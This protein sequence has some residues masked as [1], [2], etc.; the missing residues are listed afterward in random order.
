MEPG[1][2]I[3]FWNKIDLLEERIFDETFKC[4]INKYG[5]LCEI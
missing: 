3:G 1:L 4:E 5:F 2:Q